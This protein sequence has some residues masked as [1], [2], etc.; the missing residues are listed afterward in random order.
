MAFFKALLLT[1]FTPTI[2]PGE[3]PVVSN[4]G[5]FDG[6]PFFIFLTLATSFVTTDAS[7]S[8][9]PNNLNNAFSE[10]SIFLKASVTLS[11]LF[12]EFNIAVSPSVNNGTV[13]PF[14]DSIAASAIFLFLNKEGNM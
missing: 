11:D 12:T 10:L 8:F 3:S 6:S 5:F 9:S 7:L 14:A 13:L 2:I 1:S 4:F